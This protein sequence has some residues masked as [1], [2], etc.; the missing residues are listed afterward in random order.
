MPG[1]VTPDSITLNGGTLMNMTQAVDASTYHAGFDLSISGNRGITLGASGGTIRDGYGKTV[2]I[3][4]VISGTGAL[5]IFND[6][7]TVKL[8]AAN[9]FNGNTTNQG[10]TQLLLT[11]S[12][13]LQNSTL[14]SGG[15]NF[16]F[17]SSV[18]SHAFTFG[19]ISGSNNLTLVDNVSNPI[20]LT[21][22]NNNSSTTYSG[23]LSGVAGSALN[24]I[25]NGTLTLSGSNSYSNGT[26]ISAGTL[27]A[28][29]PLATGS[30]TGTGS[31]TVSASTGSGNY[32]GAVLGGNGSVSGAVTLIAGTAAKLGGII[33][34]GVDSSTNGTLT[35]GNESWNAG[36]AYQW[37]INAAGTAVAAGNVTSLT[38]TAGANNDLLK[39]SSSLNS[40]TLLSISGNSTVPFTI[41]PNGNLT[42][43]TLGS[44]KT[45]N[46]ELAQIGNSTSTQ[47]SVNGA[48]LSGNSTANLFATTNA[49]A[50]DTSGLNV[51]SSNSQ[52]L[53]ASNFSL[54]FETISGTNDLVLSYNAAPEP[55][56]AMLVLAGGLPLLQRRRRRTKQSFQYHQTLEIK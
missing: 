44:S 5:T 20:A 40:G 4:S 53:S 28:N 46:W 30:A 3:N 39:I 7:G 32:T 35:T 49:F 34:A 27:R 47:I 45:Y 17:D 22:G 25:G 2:T 12:L 15:T 19:G 9:T 21:I 36:A 50:L 38:N 11:N 51:G 13:A 41:A 1:S 33:T 18:A 16:A 37:K 43:M 55:G 29:T 6:G 42:G 31:V 24:K 56:T 48:T 54:Y 10:G 52:F 14:T 8:A 26:M 23:N